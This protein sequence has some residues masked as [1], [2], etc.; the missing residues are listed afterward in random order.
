MNE[1][2]KLD[3]PSGVGVDAVVRWDADSRYTRIE[4][5]MVW[6]GLQL[7]DLEWVLRYGEESDVMKDRHLIASVVSAYQA[8]I[9]SSQ[10]R[11]NEICKALCAAAERDEVAEL[12]K[13]TGAH[14][15]T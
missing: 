6:P 4:P 13:R 11:R 3:A 10:K 9:R 12:G 14:P 15:Y 5:D 1:T 7:G 2:T 8:L